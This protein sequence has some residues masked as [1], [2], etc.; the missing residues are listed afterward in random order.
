MGA[1]FGSNCPGR[2]DAS[3]GGIGKDSVKLQLVPA[4]GS[5]RTSEDC[6]QFG[7]GVVIKAG[8]KYA[9]LVTI[10]G[11]H[12]LRLTEDLA[13]ARKLFLVGVNI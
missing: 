7:D 12:V 4:A 10:G 3:H 1:V 11:K 13:S 5:T 6:I 9:Q 8:G 2:L